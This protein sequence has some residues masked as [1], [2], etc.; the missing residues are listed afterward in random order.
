MRGVMNLRY[1]IHALGPKLRSL[2]EAFRDLTETYLAI[3][4]EYVSGVRMK[5]IDKRVSLRLF[6][7]SS[8]DI[9]HSEV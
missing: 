4:K 8:G 7:M 3:F 6:P 1:V 9:F 2:G 5:I